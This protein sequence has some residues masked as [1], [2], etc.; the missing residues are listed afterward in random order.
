MMVSFSSHLVQGDDGGGEVF[1][2]V[3]GLAVPSS[4]KSLFR[5]FSHMSFNSS[6]DVLVAVRRYFL[7]ATRTSPLP[8]TCNLSYTPSKFGRLRPSHYLL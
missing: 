8:L 3:V 6:G 1:V 5:I 2:A 7:T 4:P